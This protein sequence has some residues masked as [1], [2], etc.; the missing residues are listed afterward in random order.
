MC[1][2]TWLDALQDRLTPHFPTV[3]AELVAGYADEPEPFLSTTIVNG[4]FEWFLKLRNG[5]AVAS[6]SAEVSLSGIPLRTCLRDLA[7]GLTIRQ[8]VGRCSSLYLVCQPETDECYFHIRD[9]DYRSTQVFFCYSSNRL[10]I[11]YMLHNFLCFENTNMSIEEH[12]MQKKQ[13]S[14]RDTER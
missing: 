5:R 3:I 1:S 10:Q 11:E 9:E 12:K 4:E 14:T 13:S 2:A 8:S 6:G 7:L